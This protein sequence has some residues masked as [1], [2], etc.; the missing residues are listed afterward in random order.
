MNK[1]YHEQAYG[2]MSKIGIRRLIPQNP[3]NHLQQEQKIK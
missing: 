1:D 2:W 3:I